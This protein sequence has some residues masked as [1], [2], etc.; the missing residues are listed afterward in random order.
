MSDLIQRVEA[1]LKSDGEPL[2][3]REYVEYAK[4]VYPYSVF[5]PFEEDLTK[6]ESY[7]YKGRPISSEEFYKMRSEGEITIDMQLTITGDLK[8][9]SGNNFHSR[10]V[11]D[12]AYN[13]NSFRDLLISNFPNTLK[14]Y[15][16]LQD[17]SVKATVEMFDKM[18]KGLSV[19]KVKYTEETLYNRYL[20]KIYLL[21]AEY[22]KDRPKE[23][24]VV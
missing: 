22:N 10:I 19:D 7:F 12:N 14:N 11:D 21:A 20:H 2:S 4:L 6:R 9:H 1:D 5:N 17:K 23:G 24:R 8:I 15:T 3:V 16:I 13:M 18:N